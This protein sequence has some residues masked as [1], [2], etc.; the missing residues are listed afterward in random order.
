MPRCSLW[1]VLT[2]A[3]A[4]LVLSTSPAAARLDQGRPACDYCRMIITE[5]A[6]GVTATLRDGRT[7]IFD[8]IECAAAAALTDTLPARQMRTLTFADHD[9]PHTPL[10]LARTTFVYS[11]ALESPMG[12]GLL[13]FKSTARAKA[14]AAGKPYTLLDWKGVL[15]R[16]NQVWFEGKQPMARA[17]AGPPGAAGSLPAKATGKR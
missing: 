5:P 8:A 16:I 10:P 1:T 13:A 3:L 2:L 15:A 11:A 9:A 14:V 4:S 7:M 6:F 12:Q 17:L